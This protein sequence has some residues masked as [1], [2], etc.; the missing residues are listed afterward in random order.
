[1]QLVH[2]GRVTFA[3]LQVH[4]AAILEFNDESHAHDHYNFFRA[5]LRDSSGRELDAMLERT[6]V[7]F[8]EVRGV[9]VLLS[10][11]VLVFMGGSDSQTLP[12][13]RLELYGWP[14][15]ARSAAALATPTRRRWAA[16]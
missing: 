9:P 14:C 4:H 15:R 1:M 12:A 6:L 10:M 7:F 16:C 11:L 8:E 13:S 5:K 3:E 2:G